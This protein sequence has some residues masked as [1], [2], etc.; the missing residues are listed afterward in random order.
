MKSS[1]FLGQFIEDNFY[2]LRT[3]IITWPMFLEE[4]K[5]KMLQQAGSFAVFVSRDQ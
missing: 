4:E 1:I 2:F 3:I 5:R